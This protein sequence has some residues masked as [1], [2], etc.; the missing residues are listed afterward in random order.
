MLLVDWERASSEIRTE[1]S[2]LALAASR[3]LVPAA[4]AAAAAVFTGAVE[5]SSASVTRPPPPS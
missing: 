2:Q 3:H 5:L 4:A 1:A